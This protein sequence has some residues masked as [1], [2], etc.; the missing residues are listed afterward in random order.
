MKN[1]TFRELL[2]RLNDLPEDYLDKD[3]TVYDSQN[4]EF[5]GITDTQMTTEDDV[6]DAWHPYFVF[7]EVEFTVENQK[8]IADAIREAAKRYGNPVCL[9]RIH[10]QDRET[11]LTDEEF[12]EMVCSIITETKMW[13]SPNGTPFGSLS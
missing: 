2:D 3:A 13:D 6:L 7:N 4:D 1:L 12:E 9:D 11:V 10:G 5:H 8:T